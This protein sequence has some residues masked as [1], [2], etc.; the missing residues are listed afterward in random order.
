MTRETN[1]T[2][3]WIPCADHDVEAMESWLTDLAAQGWFLEEDGFCFAWATFV[4]G[5]PRPVRYR[6]TSSLRS[7][8]FGSEGWLGPG[9]EAL[10]LHASY[11]WEY[12][13]KRGNFYV[14]RAQDEDARELDTDLQTQALVLQAL[15]RREN[16]AILSCVIWGMLYPLVLMWT[17]PLLTVLEAGL[18]PF[19]AFLAVVLWF[20]GSRLARSLHYHRLRKALQA[21]RGLD[22][23]KPWQVHAR[24]HQV[25]RVVTGVLL[26][27][28]VVSLVSLLGPEG[29]APA[30]PLP[31]PTVAA[32]YEGT[33]WTVEEVDLSGSR[34]PVAFLA[35][36]RIHWEETA[37]V[38][39]PDGRSAPVFLLA[40]YY[41]AASPRLAEA[42]A[43][44]ELQRDRKALHKVG[45]PEVS[46]ALPPL[47]VDFALGYQNNV[48]LPTVILRRD[49]RVLRAVLLL[50][51]GSPRSLEDCLSALASS[52][53]AP[54]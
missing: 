24:R 19:V 3:R 50:G 17:D 13:A 41:D 21:G 16:S 49:N 32:L 7:M 31:F 15:H 11:G 47:P 52:L 23:R 25:H 10:A 37:Q 2:R 35:E 46:L 26:L 33:G 54:S 12:V 28:L 42:I 36:E 34:R 51:E 27:A 20:F 22:H 5:E 38:T 9:E 43:R 1:K 48:G 39:S 45:V 6:L 44:E 18:W 14:Y 40:D 30:P 53:T 8:D 4:R 29:E